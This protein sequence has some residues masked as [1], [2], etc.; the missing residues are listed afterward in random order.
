MKPTK[1]TAPIFYEG[2]A[3]DRIE[4]DIDALRA[5][6][7]TTIRVAPRT[8]LDLLRATTSGDIAQF[9]NHYPESQLFSGN[10]L[11]I[12]R[13]DNSQ[14]SKHHE[15]DIEGELSGLSQ[16]Q[17]REMLNLQE[18]HRAQQAKINYLQGE[19]DSLVAQR[20]ELKSSLIIYK[21]YR[22]GR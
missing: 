19:I 21:E 6:G 15:V 18:E 1:V 9:F 20:E 16:N 7:K 10:Y 8:T 4:G 5:I 3:I 13:N 17:L 11:A 12:T 2:L 22:Q 14:W